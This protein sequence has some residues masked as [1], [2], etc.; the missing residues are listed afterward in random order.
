MWPSPGQ[1]VIA[2]VRGGEALWDGGRQ[3]Q[4]EIGYKQET[5]H[6]RNTL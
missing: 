3:H 5:N 1:G 2:L 4:E 6:V